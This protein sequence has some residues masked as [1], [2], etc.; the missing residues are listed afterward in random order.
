MAYI[1]FLIGCHD[2]FGEDLQSDSD[3][4]RSCPTGRCW[5]VRK[6]ELDKTVFLHCWV[7]DFPDH[8]FKVRQK[9]NKDVPGC[10]A[11]SV[12]CLATDASLTADPGVLSLISARSHTFV[13][14]DHKIISTAVTRK[15]VFGVSDKA[16]FK[17]VSSATETS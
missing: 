4:P 14:I 1:F 10:I 17:Q 13:E 5:W 16:S 12:T 3:S 6:T 9:Q 11:Q 7:Q 15:P 8:S 2:K